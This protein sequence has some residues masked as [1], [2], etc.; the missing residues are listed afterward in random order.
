MNSVKFQFH[1]KTAHAAG[2]PHNGR[3]LWT[4]GTPNVGA[5]YLREHDSGRRDPLRHNLWRRPANVVPAE[6]ERGTS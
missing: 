1:G 2:D 4:G 3:R 5:N 6:A